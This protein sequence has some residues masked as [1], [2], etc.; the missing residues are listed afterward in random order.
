MDW[1]V[2]YALTAVSQVIGPQAGF[3]AKDVLIRGT[4][5]ILAHNVGG[6]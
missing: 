3:T 1:I 4:S 5:S 6:S 2:E